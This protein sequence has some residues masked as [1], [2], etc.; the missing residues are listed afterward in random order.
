M[1]M[2]FAVIFIIL[3]VGI[4]SYIIEKQYNRIDELE[5]KE[6]IKNIKKLYRIEI[7]FNLYQNLIISNYKFDYKD[8]IQAKKC[9][10]M[11]FAKNKDEA[12]AAAE[13]EIKKLYTGYTV[14]IKFYQV[15]IN[16]ENTIEFFIKEDFEK[17]I[18]IKE[19]RLDVNVNLRKLGDYL[20][21]KNSIYYLGIIPLIERI[22]IDTKNEQNT[23]EQV[24]EQYNLDYIKVRN[25]VIHAL[26]EIT[27]TTQKDI[28]VND[29]P[30]NF[31]IFI[32]NYK[33]D[34]D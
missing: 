7:Q 24:K 31:D 18:T 8:Y 15:K 4:Y 26:Q 29:V 23:I 2:M 33:G 27:L 11:I 21:K 34:K 13:K 3:I 12:T 20:N 5:L 1:E 22:E 25:D 14:H 19:L 30:E 32:S 16:T 9:V 28:K 6:N 17:F 10:I